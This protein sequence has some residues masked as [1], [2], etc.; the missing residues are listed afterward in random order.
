MQQNSTFIQDQLNSAQFYFK[1]QLINNEKGD[2]FY[3]LIYQVGFSHTLP[4]LLP[5]HIN[6]AI[7]SQHNSAITF[8]KSAFPIYVAL[9]CQSSS[10]LLA[11]QFTSGRHYQWRNKFYQNEEDLYN[12]LAAFTK[13]LLQKHFQIFFCLPTHERLGITENNGAAAIAVPFVN[14]F[15]LELF[16]MFPRN[17]TREKRIGHK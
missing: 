10:V 9:Q 16:H 2:C 13:C 6:T 12:N 15:L 1:D 17:S 4:F 5:L 3:K 7:S 11:L 8:Y 14:L